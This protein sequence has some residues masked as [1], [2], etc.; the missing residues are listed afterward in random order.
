[1]P[2]YRSKTSTH[3]RNMAGARG[4]WRATGM[5]D[6]DFGKPIIAVVNSFTQFVPGHVHLKDLGQLV[7]R[8]IEASG[9]VAKEFNT[10]AVDDGIAM[11]H[12]GM[13]YS[14]PSRDL[15][16]DSVEYMVNAHC[17]DAMVCISNC[18]KIT[19]GM[20]MAAMRLNI[21]VV[22]VSGGPME[23]GKVKF[24]GDEKAI[25]L[26][27]AMVVAADESYTDE[28]VAAF[29]RSACPTCG[30]CS[31]M[32]TANSMN[33]LTEA[34]GLSLP[35]NGSIVATH[36]NR[37]K[38]FLRAG[39]LVVELAKRYY[40]QNDDSILPRS[41]ATKDAFE[42]AM[43]LD[44]AMGGS[45]NT[46]LHLLAA[47]HEAE[48]DFT[49]DDID[50]LSRQVPVL[51]K[52]APAKQD[53][54]MEDV[55]RAGGIMAILGELDRAKLLKTSCPTVHEPTLKDALD[56]WDIIRTED[57]DVYEFYR[58][59]PGGIPT[60]V[61]FSQNRYYS[62]L[63]GDRE[64]GVIRNA[65]HAFSKDGGLAV[66]YGNIALDGC[67][68]KTAGVDESILKFTGTARV[69]ESQDAAVEA[70]LDHKIVAGDIVVIRYEGP[71]GGPGM[72]EM[73]YPTSYLKSKGLG[74]DCAL[75]TDGRFSGGSSGLSIGHVS[76]E[77]AE[78]GAIGLVEDG[79]TIEI[80]IPNR[81]IHLNV[82]DAT[83]AHRRTV[84]EA[85]GWHPA[86]ERK[87][88]V[89]K[90]LKIYAMHSTSAAKGAVRVL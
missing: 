33:C 19:P 7:A 38:L 62:T 24:R 42:N 54:H 43:T 87:R 46:V 69:F 67:I 28:E 90:S 81:T 16:A 85:K 71:R 60:Q 6:E 76:P 73:L 70:I 82:D 79:D 25:D 10:I 12:D 49:M 66:L 52:V 4:L 15:I 18:D 23:A 45:T 80:D 53:V 50:R 74:K 41:I 56:K 75:I 11:G 89:S 2:D 48:V 30:S 58:S 72:Q 32:F 63:D 35:G 22:F 84:Q 13:L 37:E 21:P 88:K 36:A 3:G 26:V 8:E 39:R 14:L 64:K 34:L 17:A 51:S 61:A 27:D 20:L 40:E 1:M 47:A 65:E 83:L 55:H 57:A 44:I 9:G 59:S 5:K 77:A 29:E 31:G 86:E 78:G 68:V